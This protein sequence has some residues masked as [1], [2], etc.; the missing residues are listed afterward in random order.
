MP[1]SAPTDCR[2]QTPDPTD[3][4]AD[5]QFQNRRAGY[6][7]DKLATVEQWARKGYCLSAGEGAVLVEEIDRLR[8]QL[9][10]ANIDAIQAL[11]EGA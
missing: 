9:R 2:V 3:A 7:T 1:T 10:L 4:K 5:G 6:A 8:E 11:L